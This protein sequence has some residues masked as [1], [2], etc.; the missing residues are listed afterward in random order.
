MT[1][2]TP[3][4]RLLSSLGQGFNKSASAMAQQPGMTSAGLLT[5]IPK[6]FT[7]IPMYLGSGIKGAYDYLR[8]NQPAPQGDS[9]IDKYES[10]WRDVA[11]NIGSL[12]QGLSEDEIIK[13]QQLKAAESGLFIGSLAGPSLPY[14]KIAKPL[15]GLE[16]AKGGAAG[17]AGSKTV[18]AKGLLSDVITQGLSTPLGKSI[19]PL[20]VG[21]GKTTVKGEQLVKKSPLTGSAL[22]ERLANTLNPKSTTNY[23][24][25]QDPHILPQLSKDYGVPISRIDDLGEP[26]YK[27]LQSEQISTGKTIEVN[28]F[29]DKELKSYDISGKGKALLKEELRKSILDNQKYK[30]LDEAQE[31]YDKTI[32]KYH[33]SKTVEN[34][35]LKMSDLIENE[36]DLARYQD[37]MN[38][39]QEGYNTDI[40]VSNAQR[41]RTNYENK[42]FDSLFSGDEALSN[43]IKQKSIQTNEKIID[44]LMK[45]DESGELV[46]RYDQ[47][48][49]QSAVGDMGRVFNWFKSEPYI[50]DLTQTLEALPHAALNNAEI[51]G[52]NYGDALRAQKGASKWIKGNEKLIQDTVIDKYR[53]S[54]Q[55]LQ[56]QTASKS[57]ADISKFRS[58]KD[59]QKAPFKEGLKVLGSALDTGGYAFQSGARELML[60]DNIIPRAYGQVKAW[61]KYAEGTKEF[62]KAVVNHTLKFMDD[63]GM[64]SPKSKYVTKTKAGLGKF[65]YK[66]EDHIDDMLHQAF[67]GQDFLSKNLK[68]ST[69]F[70]TKWVKGA[71]QAKLQSFNNIKDTLYTIGRTGK[72]TDIQRAKIVNGLLEQGLGLA[73]FGSR[74]AKVPGLFQE[75]S[76]PTGFAGADEVPKTIST[77]LV[78]EI[79][80]QLKFDTEFRNLLREG[81]W[82]KILGL[83]GARTESVPFIG[84]GLGSD[85]SAS[86]IIKKLGN[87]IER[88]IEAAKQ[89]DISL[90]AEGVYGT[91]IPSDV[92]IASDVAISGAPY[93]STGD[94]QGVDT[95]EHPLMSNTSIKKAGYSTK[96]KPLEYLA[97]ESQLVKP[98]HELDRSIKEK[99]S[100]LSLKEF[101]KKS[102]IKSVV[103]DLTSV[104]K[105]PG[106]VEELLTSM[107]EDR[108]TP[109][110]SKVFKK[111]KG[112]MSDLLTLDTDLVKGNLPELVNI[113]EKEVLSLI[114]ES[115]V[116]EPNSQ[117][118]LLLKKV[119]KLPKLSKE[120]KETVKEKVKKLYQDKLELKDS[121]KE[122][123]L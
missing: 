27:K 30:S 2:P 96:N 33:N 114:A 29:I 123:K 23:I 57:F 46:K 110:K 64:I 101:G 37:Y 56:E 42:Y 88:S 79:S 39:V 28:Q 21:I 106:R 6:G 60:V 65:S 24:K 118:I 10:G 112:M 81:L 107:I 99:Y 35:L 94:K 49:T 63:V 20:L 84:A 8:G 86:L 48:A 61:G 115:I 76:D 18:Q 108:L 91:I 22:Q 66:V 72:V 109:T 34:E 83:S 50:G 90:L 93:S 105:D 103:K 116:H 17:I 44:D 104:Y 51:F 111:Y 62:N 89:G 45:I 40:I 7:D 80:L 97:Q 82:G 102:T 32:N 41:L 15:K 47:A 11:T 19:D 73:I 87:I 78:N 85:I 53:H 75:M 120:Q 36:Q 68:A 74:G 12:G 58:W 25:S 119:G 69:M 100:R 113:S 122:G 59:I 52:I 9:F 26:L 95:E 98:I 55:A 67:S 71:V 38:Q 13:E 54:I 77:W 43:S 121:Y 14:G 1:N 117:S 92:D 31:L 16:A 4:Q 5:G 3:S 70:M